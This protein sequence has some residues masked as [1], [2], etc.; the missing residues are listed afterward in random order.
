MTAWKRIVLRAIVLVAAAGALGYLSLFL[1]VKSARFQHWLK[2]KIA[3]RTGYEVNARDLTILPPL[4]LV[5]Y[6]AAIS[7]S[8]KTLLQSE[9]VALSFTPI[10]LLSKSIHRLD[11]VKPTLYL[12][13]HQFVDSSSKTSFDVTIRHLN[14]RDGT[15]VLKTGEGDS[16]DFRSIMMDAENFN[17]GGTSGVDLSVE[18]P[19]LS[20]RADIAVRGEGNEKTVGISI[21]QTAAK[22]SSFSLPAKNPPDAVRAEV[23]LRKNENR[24]L[25]VLATGQLNELRMANEKWSGSF[26][27][28]AGVDAAFKEFAFSGKIIAPH[29]PPKIGAVPLI[30]NKGPVTS[31]IEGNYS[32]AEKQIVLKSL[33]LESASGSA[34]GSGNLDFSR[35]F[36]VSGGRLNLRNISVEALKSLLPEWLGT[37]NYRGTTEADLEFEGAWPALVIKGIVRS[38]GT[39][40][41]S[42]K[43]SL[44]QLS[45]KAPFAWTNGSTRVE[46]LQLT[47]KMLAIDQKDQTKISA[48]EILVDAGLEKTGSTPWKVSAKV[49]IR[50]GRFAKP[51]GSKVAENLTLSGRF[52]A[53]TIPEKSIVA[54]AGKLDIEQGELLWG[55]FFGDFKGQRPALDFDG[56][57]VRSDDLLRLRRFNLS[58]TNIGTLDLAGSFEH[59]TKSPTISVTVQ[60]ADVKPA[61]FFDFFVRDTL[62]KSYPILDQLA[63]GGRVSFSARAQGSF[64]DLSAAGILQLQAGNIAAKSNK[65]QVGPVNLTLPF[66]V[67]LP[68]AKS[69]IAKTNIRAGTLVLESARLDTE[70]I[71]PVKTTL[72]LRNN[73]LKFEQPVRIGIYGGTVEIRNLA[74]SDVIAHPEAVSFA[75]ETTDLQLQ[76]LAEALDWYRFSGTLSGSIPLV[77][78]TERS[79][80]SQ[81]QIQVQVFGGRIQISK[82]E[83]ENPFSSFPSIKLDSRFQQIDL[84]QASRTFEFGRISGILE[85]R[86]NDLVITNGQPSQF[87]AD[88]HSVEKGATSQWISVEALNKITV[89]SSGNN[90]GALYGGLAGLFDSFRYSKLG[91]K[92]ALKNDKLMLRGI[93]SRDGKEYLV[94]GSILPPTV[95]V[96]S[97]TQEI[98]FGE[99]LRRLKQIQKSDK[100]QLN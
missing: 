44:A 43:F 46:D 2:L 82:M 37:W 26:D 16:L 35:Q 48:E 64:D 1:I 11:L 73:A 18:I 22:K 56:D 55:K 71:P 19:W 38:E 4:R 8:S 97:H 29:L 10:G 54:V 90:A 50:R 66:R 51:D 47:G 61:A 92:A 77:E 23:K 78:W 36:S 27:I 12:D 15:V 58:L 75:I 45:F 41:K 87:M 14:I 33:R 88:V 80:R 63:L 85:G 40:W 7:H 52:G 100:P 65:W 60:S 72:S 49:Q 83:I 34:N 20:A 99:L 76:R 68:A 25:E 96:I 79:L 69:E 86:M 39:H 74:W 84:E 24:E 13:P 93:E 59:V 57:Y 53:T 5:A 95:N 94:V 9:K 32:I 81:G 98:G 89:L 28:N 42:E 21:Q 30:L 62:K 31:T 6:S 3:N 17:V 70:S 91:F 67:H